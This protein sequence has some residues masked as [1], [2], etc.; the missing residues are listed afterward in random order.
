MRRRGTE[1]KKKKKKRREPRLP[2]TMSD[3]NRG[4]L[5][6]AEDE[7]RV[8]SRR[9]IL[10]PLGEGRETAYIITG[11]RPLVKRLVCLFYFL[12]LEA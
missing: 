4:C 11:S 12:D 7:E 2:P 10:F 5:V 1:G 3:G 8:L 9:L 6:G